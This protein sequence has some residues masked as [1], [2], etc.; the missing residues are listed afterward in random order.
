MTTSKTKEEDK[1]D[2]SEPERS[3][4]I[5]PIEIDTHFKLFGKHM[6]EVNYNDYCPLCEKKIDEFGYCAC[7]ASTG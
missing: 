5:V 4:S 3:F 6:W 1:K 7:N 2:K